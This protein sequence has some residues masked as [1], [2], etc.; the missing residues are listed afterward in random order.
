MQFQIYL[1]RLSYSVPLLQMV[2]LPRLCGSAKQ[3]GEFLLNSTLEQQTFGAASLSRNLQL[4]LAW[5]LAGVK[6]SIENG[7]IDRDRI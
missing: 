6:I 7:E 3:I 5:S 2:R 1:Q 4:Q